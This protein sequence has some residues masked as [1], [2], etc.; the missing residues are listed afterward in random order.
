MKRDTQHLLL[1]SNLQLNGSQPVLKL[2]QWLSMIGV[3][4]WEIQD[5]TICAPYLTLGVVQSAQTTVRATLRIMCREE[6]GQSLQGRVRFL[7]RRRFQHG[8]NSDC[9]A[10]AFSARRRGLGIFAVAPELTRLPNQH[11]HVLFDPLCGVPGAVS[12][13]ASMRVFTVHRLLKGRFMKKRTPIEMA[14]DIVSYVKREMD[15]PR[16][17][18]SVRNSLS[19]PAA[20]AD[21]KPAAISA[22]A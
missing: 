5:A 13:P 6:V 3:L 10:G 14:R 2:C 15:M 8:N 16:L 1:P 22:R 4:V 19:G 12:A 11:V 9:P 20:P 7:L 17:T 18:E 21:E